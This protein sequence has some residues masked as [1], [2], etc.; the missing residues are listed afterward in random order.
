MEE[1]IDNIK[2]IL[3]DAMRYV[4][5]RLGNV[6]FTPDGNLKNARTTVARAWIQYQTSLVNYRVK[7]G[8]S[9]R[10]FSQR[11]LEHV[12][13]ILGE[14][15]KEAQLE[16]LRGEL[17][18]V[19]DLQPLRI[20]MRALIAKDDETDLSVFAHFLQLVKRNIEH[21]PVTYHIMPVL[22]GPQGSGKSEAL[23]KLFAPMKN[24]YYLASLADISDERRSHLLIDKFVAVFDELSGAKFAD[25]NKLKSTITAPT[26]TFRRLYTASA[27]THTQ[28]T[29]FIGTSNRAL[30]EQIRDTTGQRRFY[31]IITPEKCD[32]DTLN[33]IDYTILWQGISIDKPY[34]LQ[35]AIKERQADLVHPDQIESY[36]EERE[37]RPEQNGATKFVPL[38]LLYKDYQAW[39]NECGEKPKSKSDFAKQLRTRQI[40]Y[41]RLTTKRVMS[42]IINVKANSPLLVELKG[43][44]W[45][46]TQ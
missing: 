1:Q 12:Y 35:E 27:E 42:Y 39:T 8:G 5:E 33:R 6:E 44:P 43:N 31:E 7:T 32:W 23:K 34:L 41:K 4:K 46:V 29:S 45:E 37:L 38:S 21:M 9:L 16:K 2:L 40:E 36:I 19:E 22:R 11:D 15:Y 3:S 10:G 14:E 25:L 18:G 30:N 28:R 24:Y 20:F 26:V 13:T 17:R